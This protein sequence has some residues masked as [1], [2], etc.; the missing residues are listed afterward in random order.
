MV[1]S[2]LGF[3]DSSVFV[4]ACCISPQLSI[5]TNITASARKLKDKEIFYLK[6][7]K[8][9][10]CILEIPRCFKERQSKEKEHCV[11]KLSC[12]KKLTHQFEHFKSPSSWSFYMRRLVKP[13][14]QKSHQTYTKGKKSVWKHT[15]S[16]KNNLL[17][18]FWK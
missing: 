6:F 9:D 2:N 1:K 5:A 14:K 7:L 10:D 16:G 18:I 8:K 4:D 12:C 11:Y 15:K 13:L 17:N 3:D